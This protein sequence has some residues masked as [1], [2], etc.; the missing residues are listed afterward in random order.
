MVPSSIFSS[1]YLGRCLLKCFVCYDSDAGTYANATGLSACYKCDAGTYSTKIDGIFGAWNCTLCVAG[2]YAA[3]PSQASC[4]DC[5][6]GRAQLLEGSAECVACEP[7]KHASTSGLQQCN[8]CALGFATSSTGQ[9]LCA[10]CDSGLFANVTG[11]DYCMYH[12]FFSSLIFFSRAFA[13]VLCQ[14]T[15]PA[16]VFW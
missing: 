12:L 9:A 16:S 13:T 3:V 4:T 10:A 15:E 14:L 2:R 7:G 8:E 6:I 1:F 11:L 5:P